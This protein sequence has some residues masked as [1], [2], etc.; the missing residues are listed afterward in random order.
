MNIRRITPIFILVFM[1][2]ILTIFPVTAD[3]ETLIARRVGETDK[4]TSKNGKNNGKLQEANAT[5]DEKSGIDAFKGCSLACALN[6]DVKCSSYLP[7][8]GGNTY[9]VDMLNDGDFRTAWVEGAK[10][11]GIGEWVEF[12]IKNHPGKKVV[13]TT[14]WGVNISNGYRKSKDLWAKNSRVKQLRMDI[15]GKPRLAINL[16]DSMFNQNIGFKRLDIK[17]GDVLRFTITGI[18]PG[19]KYKDTC[20][21]ELI[22]M[23]A[24]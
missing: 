23:G 10:G 22:P 1:L 5:I 2:N 9:T 13:S 16:K 8:S 6:W 4:S 3:G 14:F 15:N 19:S 17:P 12:R 11:D 18:Y 24:H 20:I 21:T 7:S